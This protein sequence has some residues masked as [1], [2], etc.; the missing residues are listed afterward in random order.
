[1]LTSVLP[2]YKGVYLPSE[3]R[4][5]ATLASYLSTLPNMANQPPKY[6]TSPSTNQPTPQIA[7]ANNPVTNISRN[8]TAQ[9]N[10]LP[11]GLNFRIRKISTVRKRGI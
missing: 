7:N 9:K 4:L 5:P 10:F 2:P 8:S 11:R 1:M 6:T 3:S